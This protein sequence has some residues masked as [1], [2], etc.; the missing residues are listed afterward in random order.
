M[1]KVFFIKT[2]KSYRNSYELINMSK[3]SEN[4]LYIYVDA[5]SENCGSNR[6]KETRVLLP[7][8]LLSCRTHIERLF[9]YTTHVYV[10]V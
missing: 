8:F 6:Q 4:A 7:T 2:C 5:V 10:F 1:V 9:I 3:C